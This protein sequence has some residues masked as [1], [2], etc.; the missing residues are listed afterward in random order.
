VDVDDPAARELVVDHIER[1]GE[2]G[3]GR[4]PHVL[5]RP[6]HVPGDGFRGDRSRLVQ[7]VGVRIELAVLGEVE[8]ERHARAK[9]RLDPHAR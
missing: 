4:H 1:R 7:Q 2:I 5:D 3:V 8:E 9:D 6:P